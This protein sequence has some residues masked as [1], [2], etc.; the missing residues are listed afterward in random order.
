MRGRAIPFRNFD[1]AQR[2]ID[3]AH[4]LGE[5]LQRVTIA[6]GLT[7]GLLA[8]TYEGLAGRGGPEASAQHLQA[9]RCREAA[10]ECR[11]FAERLA[12]LHVIDHGAPLD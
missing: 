8:E 4:L 5:R 10:Y 11:S 1:Q 9:K 12:H 7:E 2:L 3:E 6:L